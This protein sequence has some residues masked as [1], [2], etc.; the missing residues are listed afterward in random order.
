MR[1][2]SISILTVCGIDELPAQSDRKVSHVLS[3][4]DPDRHGIDAFERFGSHQR[5]I[6][7]FH[8]IIDA[9]AGKVM[10]Q[11]QHV[12]D[13]VAFGRDLGASR[14][15]RADGHLLVHCHMGSSRSTAAMLTLLAQANPAE[16]EDSLFRRLRAIRPRAW[17][18]SLMIGFADDALGRKGRLVEALR[19]HYRCQVD[20]HADLARWM[21]ELGREREVRMADEGVY[22]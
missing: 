11:P 14:A 15:G 18:N 10:P 9:E 20:A 8:D 4:L 6:L 7:R 22:S 13:I 1:S 3:L 16:D 19:R 12:A 5:T 17:P 2:L 21:V